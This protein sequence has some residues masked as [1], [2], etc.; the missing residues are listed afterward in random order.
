MKDIILLKFLFKKEFEALSGAIVDIE[1]FERVEVE[2]AITSK[3]AA[4]IVASFSGGGLIFASLKCRSDLIEIA[5]FLKKES[6]V[7]SNTN[8]K[9][10]VIDFVKNKEFSKLLSKLHV[11][12]I[13]DS[14]IEIK[15]LKIKLAL[16]LSPF[17]KKEKKEQSFQKLTEENVSEKDKNEV[18]QHIKINWL[19]PIETDD[20]IWIIKNGIDIK[21]MLSCWTIHVVGPSP[22]VARWKK[23][24]EGKWKFEL[25][26]EKDEGYFS[27]EGNWF[28]EGDLVP[29]FR[30]SENRWIFKGEKCDLYFSNNSYRLTR[31]KSINEKK[32]DVSKNS[33]SALSKEKIISNSF[34]SEF[35][36]QSE[37][38]NEHDISE[39]VE[40]DLKLNT[41]QSLEKFE[42]RPC[43]E[44]DIY[45]A[46]HSPV[47]SELKF[48]KGRVATFKLDTRIEAEGIEISSQ[49]YDFT[50]D[51][52]VFRIDEMKIELNKNV[53]VK[54][55]YDFYD[56]SEAFV[57]AGVVVKFE[58]ECEKNR[59]VI[60]KVNLI[61]NEVQRLI[62]MMEN[63]QREGLKIFLDA[64][65][66]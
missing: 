36:V 28:Y 10:V 18:D 41:C 13:V 66:A 4:T 3:E 54:F 47:P 35:V 5:S 44:L 31:F 34:K 22:A 12:E 62:A 64:K 26:G 59:F 53:R 56:T 30:W 39:K 50:D 63:S 2:E 58:G 1:K 6:R 55:S 43:E 29:E 57:I 40:I 33:M 61:N 23:E 14:D 49:L 37:S 7:L 65:G 16:W 38:Q 52:F 8:F 45:E 24:R 11:R 27:Q 20:D 15:T 42:K 21:L 46:D 32:M 17:L 19:S 9:L 25:N 51:I 48:L 60:V